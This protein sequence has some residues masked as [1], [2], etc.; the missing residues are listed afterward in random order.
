M[1]IILHIVYIIV[2]NISSTLCNSTN[3]YRQYSVEG[4]LGDD[5]VGCLEEIFKF[6]FVSAN[7]LPTLT[8]CEFILFNTLDEFFFILTVNRGGVRQFQISFVL[9]FK[10]FSTVYSKSCSIF[11]KQWKVSGYRVLNSFY[12]QFI[13]G[14]C[15]T[16]EAWYYPWFNASESK[17]N[18]SYTSIIFYCILLTTYEV[19]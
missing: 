16:N 13:S 10:V 1:C 18:I 2:F 4:K 5:K 19:I 8:K 14:S 11:G 3:E 17:K 9:I 15:T 7:D 12:V 6:N